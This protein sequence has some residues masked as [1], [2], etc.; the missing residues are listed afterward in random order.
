VPDAA[1]TTVTLHRLPDGSGGTRWLVAS[2][3]GDASAPTVWSGVH[4]E[5]SARVHSEADA[6]R[7]TLARALRRPRGRRDAEALAAH[8]RLLFDLLL[9]ATAKSVLRS[10]GAGHLTIV[11][12]GCALPWHLLHDGTAFLGLRWS[13]GRLHTTDVPPPPT[14]T[15]GPRRLLILADPA[16]DLPAARY[17]GDALVRA[18]TRAGGG[19]PCELRPGPVT[20]TDC[21][22]LLAGARLV[23]FAGHA[24][25]A[26]GHDEGGFRLSDGHIGPEALR[27]TA[28]GAAPMLFF[29]NACQ[30][31]G[32]DGALVEAL[33][34]AGVRHIV[35]T[36]VDLP[37]LP[38]ADLARRFY[39]GLADGV[40]IGEALRRARVFAAEE[41]STV[42]A[43]YGLVGAPGTRYFEARRTAESEPAMRRAIA[44]AVRRR[45][46]P[47]DPEGAASERLRGRSALAEHLERAGGR[48]LPGAGAIDRAVFGL[49]VSYENDAWRAARA[50]LDAAPLLG[51]DAV[52]VLEEGV[53]VGQGDDAVGPALDSAEAACWRLSPG[54]HLLPA[55]GRHLERQARLEGDAAG[56]R[57][58]VDLARAPTDDRDPMVGRGRE[59]SR[60][61]A[62]ADRCLDRDSPSAVTILAPAGTGKSR[63]V[64]ALAERLQDRF[65]VVRGAGRPYDE[66]APYAAAAEV[67]RALLG[68][69]ES[70]PLEAQR[71]R[72]AA[73]VEEADTRQAVTRPVADV[74]SI[75]ALL[76]EAPETGRLADRLEA[77]SAILAPQEQAAHDPGRRTGAGVVPAAFRALIEACAQERPLLVVFEDLHWL[78]EA[79]LAVVDE[80]VAALRGAPVLVVATA[81][82]ALL[83]RVP[84]WFEAAAHERLDLGP[85]STR[86]A[87]ALL[88]QSLTADIPQDRR[89]ALLAR[90]EGNPL[91]LRE[92]AQSAGDDGDGAVPATIEAVMR[93]RLDRRPHLER[94]A[95]RAGGVLGRS[96]WAEGVQ[97]LLDADRAEVDAALS[98]L[99]AHRFIARRASSSLPG[100]TE[101][102]F[103]HALLRD[104]VRA[105]APAAA[106]RA[107]HGRA[108]LWLAAEVELPAGD[109]AARVAAHHQAAGDHARAAEGWAEAGRSALARYAPGEA[110][111]ALEAAL[112]EDDAAGRHLGAPERADVEVQLGRLR[113]GAG[114]LDAAEALFDAAL[115]APTGHPAGSGADATIR[116]TRLWR[117]AELDEVRGL[118][119]AAR[120]RLDAARGALESVGED[121]AL[122]LWTL[123]ECDLGWLEQRS[124]QHAA[125]RARL[126]P[127]LD[128]SG[129]APGHRARVHNVLGASA[130]SRGAH[131]EAAVH[132]TAALQDSEAAEDAIGVAA[133]CNNLGILSERRGEWEEAVRWHTRGIRL[134]VSQGDRRGLARAY[135]NL[136]TL[137][138]TRGDLDRARAYLEESIRIRTR[139]GDG[140]A[141]VSLANLAEVLHLMGRHDEA[142]DRL[143]TAIE[144]CERG[145]GPGYLLP[146][147]RRLLGAVQLAQD[148]AEAAA[149]TALRA[150]EEARAREDRPRAGQAA[151]TLGLALARL[152][153]AEDADARLSEAIALLETVDE[154]LELGR[155]Y[156]A[157]ARHLVD[158]SPDTAE[159][160]RASARTLLASVGHEAELDG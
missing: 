143:E 153:R 31:G 85:L 98:G 91:F 100:L 44:V 128:R 97:R 116:A 63:L 123:I 99:E 109:R 92:L 105:D 69:D 146:D 59:L 158:R 43:A 126:Q 121:R 50:S 93:A 156:A 6:L 113:T 12:P 58:V 139:A 79:G 136:G 125:A 47:T 124:G 26:S 120:R 29:A 55:V 127:A 22:R 5:D 106:L 122:G 89:D 110:R 17:E 3:L 131:D 68:I 148:D 52:V 75:D 134:R 101:W 150:L 7:R 102:R 80:L 141:A 140:N 8:G 33:L 137:Y 65:R 16:R 28:G 40:A 67:L 32:A 78:P 61:T 138:G 4:L 117:R 151:R 53:L 142:R 111:T 56:P 76:A 145:R 157:R 152:G 95:L 82:P 118:V 90:A 30:S 130:F 160:L 49:P 77:L 46:A 45:L 37:D 2:A 24:D 74:L 149:E 41:D 34:S 112:S 42:W 135:N 64:G 36:T 115:T 23:H 70:A 154:P 19:L 57:R 38:G 81:R 72:L 155:A 14:P 21:L 132:Y 9:P 159:A 66:S 11:D 147:A 104:V 108:A 18:L 119:D 84:Q 35:H 107:L 27:R 94:A 86:E 39:E 13:L 48:L 15:G 103:A 114:E 73:L 25:P 129:L 83:D 62:I 144:A 96:F 71:E 51:E 20:T 60:L 87:D 54:V 10:A 1:Q 88:R 133:A